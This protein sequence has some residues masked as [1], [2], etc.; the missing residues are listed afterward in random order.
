MTQHMAGLTALTTVRRTK[1]VRQVKRGMDKIE[2]NHQSTDTKPY[3]NFD[4][5]NFWSYMEY[6]TD[7]SSSDGF[8]QA[9]FMAMTKIC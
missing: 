7:T 8:R 1:G 2:P 9:T 3:G 5:I 6:L 4:E